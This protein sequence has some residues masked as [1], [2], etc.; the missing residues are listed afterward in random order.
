MSRRGALLTALAL[1]CAASAAGEARA[2]AQGPQQPLGQQL[3]G[4]QGEPLRRLDGDALPQG[5]GLAGGDYGVETQRS[6]PLAGGDYGTPE[7]DQ[8]ALAGGDYGLPTRPEAS[9]ATIAPSLLSDPLGAA[10]G[11]FRPVLTRRRNVDADDP[12]GPVGVR[13]GTFLLRP[14][15]ETAGGYDTNP[16]RI[17]DVKKGSSFGRIRGEL[18]GQSDWSRHELA[19]R[20]SAQSRHYFDVPQA[21]YEPEINGAVTGRIDVT[22]RTQINTE[23]RGSIAASRPG[24]PETPTGIDGDE[25]TRSA[26]ATVGVAQRFNRLSLR[27]DGLI[28]RYTVDNAKLRTGAKVDNSDRAYNSYETRLRGSYELSPKLSPFVELA[29]DTRDYDKKVA[30]TDPTRKL[31]SDGYALRTGAQ[32]ELTRLVTG[33]AAIGYARQTPN[34]KDLKVVE[35]MLIDGAV[36]WAPS[37]LTTF[38]LNAK[39]GLQETT[40]TDAGGVFTRSVEASVEHKLRRNLIVTASANFENSDYQGSKPHRVDKTTTLGLEA[41]YRLNRSV[42]LISS[43]QKL[44]LNSSLPGED[45]DASIVEFGLRFRR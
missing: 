43:F 13:A 27:L 20:S 7:A 33:E 39:T 1:A 11:G 32:F 37:A 4:G 30:N 28:D 23:L 24:D 15:L 40:I 19:F 17:P 18:D 8:P 41:E 3:P 29:V 44:W 5:G 12:Y 45:Y 9:A 2:Q 38:R 21:G 10:P 6:R 36:A 35:G 26:G 31:G 16:T 42:A 34:D 22:E 14:T 25:I